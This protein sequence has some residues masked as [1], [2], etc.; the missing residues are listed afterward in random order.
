[1]MRLLHHTIDRPRNDVAGSE[2]SAGIE[3][4]HEPLP[5]P[6]N[7]PGSSPTNRLGDQ[8]AGTA[9]D[10]EHRRMKLHELHIAKQASCPPGQRH[11]IPAGHVRIGRLAVDLACATGCEDRPPSPDQGLAMVFV[12][13]KGAPAVGVVGEQVDGECV[14]PDLEV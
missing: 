9:G 13:D 12:P 8:A 4:G 3:G 11:P 7:Q 10:V 2:L 6:I 1:M 5:I 14:G